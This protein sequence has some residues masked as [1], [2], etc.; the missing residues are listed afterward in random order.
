M[1]RIETLRF[2]SDNVPKTSINAEVIT[3][4]PNKTILR[5]MN[6]SRILSVSVSNK[7]GAKIL[8][9]N[10]D[11]LE[12][13]IEEREPWRWR[14]EVH[15]FPS[16]DNSIKVRG[17]QT[18]QHF[19]LRNQ[20]SVKIEVNGVQIESTTLDETFELDIK[21]DN[22]GFE[23]WTVVTNLYETNENSNS[24]AVIGFSEEIKDFTVVSNDMNY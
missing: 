18:Y 12:S 4:N 5:P 3:T 17:C 11:V 22:Y 13:N 20:N 14:H 7:G 16:Q 10:R 9:D 2:K 24:C 15:M 8:L 21:E 6:C 19:L 1:S 23:G